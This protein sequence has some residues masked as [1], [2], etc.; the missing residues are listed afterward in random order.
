MRA[1]MMK[2]LFAASALAGL[3]TLAAAQ[4]VKI[5]TEILPLAGWRYDDLYANGISVED[6]IGSE[7]KVPRA[8]TSAMSRTSFSTGT[9]RS[10]RLWPRWAAF[11]SSATPM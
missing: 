5:K 10:C 6:L 7:V 9:G 11:S 3:P 1:M 2:V 8:M 4:E